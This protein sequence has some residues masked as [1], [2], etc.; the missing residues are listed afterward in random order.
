MRI[1]IGKLFK[2]YYK[3]CDCGCKCLVR[4]FDKSGR[5]VRY[6]RGHNVRGEL[7]TND[8]EY[9]VIYKPHYKYSLKLTCYVREHRYIMYI[10]LSILNGKPTYIEGLEV[11]HKN[12]NKKDN[13]IEN[14][15]LMT[16]GQHST[17][18]HKGK[19]RVNTSRRYCNL[20]GS[21]ESRIN[22]NNGNKDWS[23]DLDGYLCIIC[24][25]TVYNLRKRMGLSTKGY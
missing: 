22:Y 24:Y 17:L 19:Q 25:M 16:K 9:I 13:R 18:T 6:L 7:K 15:E 14:L 2:G 21:S 1:S 12:G 5:F 8:K 11:H 4:I 3:Y 20:C 23:K 10:Y